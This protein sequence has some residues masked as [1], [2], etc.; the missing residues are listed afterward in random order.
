MQFYTPLYERDRGR[1]RNK[2][3][4]KRK[5]EAIKEY[6][7]ARTPF[8]F[9]YIVFPIPRLLSLLWNTDKM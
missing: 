5:R 9:S 2:E 4:K 3:R 6:W 1:K 7:N 8:G